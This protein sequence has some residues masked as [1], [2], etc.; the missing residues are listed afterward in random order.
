MKARVI[1]AQPGVDA[2]YVRNDART[3]VVVKDIPA[4]RLLCPNFHAENLQKAKRKRRSV[5]FI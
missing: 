5:A 2:R 4:V 1:P 3:I